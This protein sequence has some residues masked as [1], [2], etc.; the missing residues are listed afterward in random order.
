MD[1][2]E[3]AAR[4]DALIAE[5][6]FSGVIRVDRAGEVLLERSVGWAH[7]AHRVPM[8]S[9]TRLAIAS[10]A[11]G[12]TALVVHSLAA[13]GIL[14]LSTPAR[15]WLG[16]DLP[17]VDD[18][19]TVEHLLAH[20]SGIGDYVD[21]SAG[22]DIADYIMP[23]PVHT[24]VNTEDYL[25]VLGG[26]PQQ[27]PPGERFAYNNGGFVVL[28]LLAERAAGIPFHDLVAARV[29]APAGLVDTAFLRSDELP[30]RTAS[31]YLEA[32]G[33]RS[34]IL[35]LPVRGSGGIYTTVD[36]IHRLWRALV[37]GKVL[38]PTVLAQAWLPRSE[39]PDEGMRYGLG[40]WLHATG[41]AVVLEGYDAGVS[42]RS[43][44]D[45]ASDTT[46]TVISNWSNGAW[47]IARALYET[48]L[49]YSTR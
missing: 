1:L 33:D 22:G 49:D 38:E 21:E 15:T 45:P 14:P 3:L 10:G 5:N 11:K 43:V 23:V 7:R 29:C 24:L 25:T 40:F 44:H 47:P 39:D 41:P 20:R 27:F 34:N 37:D 28:A 46:H 31:G 18:L 35:H 8:T 48:L 17:E 4:I 36:D 16:A 12:F 6:E 2:I 30:E 13:E 42:F 32:R 9:D 19:V 26:F